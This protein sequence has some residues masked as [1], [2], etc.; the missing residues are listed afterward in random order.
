MT[1]NIE[2]INSMSTSIFNGINLGMSFS[3]RFLCA[4]KG[5]GVGNGET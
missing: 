2:T 4:P 3:H 1:V 5:K